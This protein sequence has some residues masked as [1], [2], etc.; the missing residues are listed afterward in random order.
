MEVREKKYVW[1]AKIIFL[2]NSSNYMQ[3][4]W[5]NQFFHTKNSGKKKRQIEFVQK[6]KIFNNLDI[7]KSQWILW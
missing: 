6:K 4:N 3:L 1:M 5:Q 7:E 2:E